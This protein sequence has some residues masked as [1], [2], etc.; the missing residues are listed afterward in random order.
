MFIAVK[1]TKIIAIRE[2]EWMCRRRVKGLD[3]S[4]YWTGLE[5]VTTEDE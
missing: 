1:D 4:D 2:V 5:S 3:K